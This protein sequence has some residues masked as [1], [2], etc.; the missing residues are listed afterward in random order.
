MKYLCLFL[1]VVF[2]STLSFAQPILVFDDFEGNGT[3]DTWY[4]DDCSIST[5]LPNPYPEGINTSATV[6]GYRDNGG[7]YANIGFNVS[8]NFDLETNHTFSF[9]IYVPSDSLTGNETNVVSVK[10][11]NGMLQQPWKSQSVINGHLLQTMET[12]VTNQKIRVQGLGG[13]SSGVYLINLSVGDQHY[14][15]KFIKQ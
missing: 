5:E 7:Q 4:G 8:N 14:N 13:L 12:I 2:F 15:V 1:F 3:I 11:Q 10:L 9:K 6:M